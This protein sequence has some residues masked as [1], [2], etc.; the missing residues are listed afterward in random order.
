ME[1]LWLMKRCWRYVNKM[2]DIMV[3]SVSSAPPSVDH[4]SSGDVNA[5]IIFIPCEI[6]F[7]LNWNWSSITSCSHFR[8]NQQHQ[9]LKQRYNRLPGDLAKDMN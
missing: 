4:I 9:S 6:V 7:K 1:S 2:L 5:T 3:S 8:V